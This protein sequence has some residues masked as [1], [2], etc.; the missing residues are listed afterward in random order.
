MSRATTL[1]E[2]GRDRR[3][4]DAP[5]HRLPQ[6][7]GL[8]HR[9]PDDI[10]PIAFEGRL[11]AYDDVDMELLRL[12]ASATASPAGSRSTASR[13]SSNDANL[14]PARRHDRRH[15]RRRRVDRCPCRC[16]TTARPSGSSPWP[17][18]ASTRSPRTTCGILTILADRAATAVGSSRL[19]ART[20]ALARE[21]RRLLDM[22][23]ELS[24]S[25]DPRQVADLMAGHLATAMGVNECIISY[26]DRSA[27]RVESLGL[28]P[29]PPDQRHR[30]VVRRGR[31]PRD[32]CASSNARWRSSWT[33]T[34]RRP[35][36]PRST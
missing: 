18:W 32:A 19:L 31:L 13:S 26:W 6:R 8:P 14:D 11:G 3:R 25:L 23:A 20:Q 5:D 15:R 35:T 33:S 16:A 34:T 22:S 12:H 30:A 4:G 7:P 17:S 27:G 24:G 2:V 36:A 29:A 21:M 28:L 10:V 1:E 9:P